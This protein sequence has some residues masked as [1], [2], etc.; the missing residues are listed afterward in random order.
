MF[1]PY[2]L[3][4]LNLPVHVLGFEHKA[5]LDQ[6]FA[7]VRMIPTICKC[8]NGVIYDKEMNL[9]DLNRA[10]ELLKDF[11]SVCVK[12]TYFSSRGTG[13][14]RL[15]CRN[16]TIESLK[17]F[18]REFGENFLVQEVLE[19]YPKLAALSKGSLN[20]FRISTLYINGVCSVCTIIS[21]I[22]R[23][24]S[25]VD[26]G[27]AG[28]IF[29]GVEESG[30]YAPVGYDIK[31]NEYKQTDTG[32]A[33][34]DFKL[35]EIKDLVEEVKKLHVKYLPHCGFCGWDF[36]LDKSGQWTMVEVNLYAPSVDIEQ[37]GPHKPLFGDRTE[38]VIDYVNKH[39]PSVLAITTSLGI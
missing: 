10:F 4:A 31:S 7:G 15:D 14:K 2:I 38:E 39:Q 36:S 25:F 26:N 6:I 24:N 29:V 27:F 35:E 22:G 11:D 3:R 18:L 16:L 23:G 20:T 37:I 8:I 17:Q 21:R 9:I 12:K 1:E 28:N 19:Q 33:F 13:V 30:K 32:V 34:S 5:L